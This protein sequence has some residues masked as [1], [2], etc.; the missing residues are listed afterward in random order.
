VSAGIPRN[1]NSVCLLAL[2]YGMEQ[3]MQTISAE[4]IRKVTRNWWE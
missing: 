2:Q 1:I 4:V 3:G